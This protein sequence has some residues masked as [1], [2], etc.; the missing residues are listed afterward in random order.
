VTLDLFLDL[1]LL[2]AL[3]GL[4]AL[5]ARTLLGTW[6]PTRIAALAFPIG[7][8][9]LTWLVFLGSWLGLRVALVNVALILGIPVAICLWFLGLQKRRSD[10]A[11][12][13][14]KASSPAQG[15]SSPWLVGSLGALALLWWAGNAYLS[16]AGSY[17][18]WDSVAIWSLKGYAIAREGSVFAARTWGAHGLA[19][20][21]NNP[22]LISLFTL[23]GGDPLPGS[24]VLFPLYFA[25]LLI[26]VYGFGRTW[27]LRREVAGLAV[28]FVASI[29]VL[30]KESTTGYANVPMTACLVLGGLT[31]LEGAKASSIGKLLTGGALLGLASWIRV[32][33]VLYAAAILVSGLIA[34]A[35]FDRARSK[36]LWAVVPLVVI[37]GP[38]LAFYRLYGAGS[39][40]AMGSVSLALEAFRSGQWHLGPLRL[41][42][43]EVIRS[44]W[45]IK[46]WGWVWPLSVILAGLLYR[47]ASRAGRAG[48]LAAAAMGGGGALTTIVLFYI[49]SFGNSLS[50]WLATTF[51][52]E[53][54]PVPLLVF[55]AILPLLA[56]AFR[57]DPDGLQTR[58]QQPP[59]AEREPSA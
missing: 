14:P 58:N 46:S 9:V 45:D 52:R 31:V 17:S 4:G 42:V 59:G 43:Q 56:S 49:S 15:R 19:Y 55:A 36:W 44:M 2:A 3:L 38:W 29:P 37:V 6:E 33:G 48:F 51:G 53:L 11:T 27:G 7:S 8:G 25:S 24:K 34:I 13:D 12:P 23:A 10:H 41:I 20:P 57:T 54:L 30:Y 50:T 40:Q 47:R 16:V 5:V 22:L 21:L 35:F 28:L 1:V 39:S 18:V 32:E 26:G